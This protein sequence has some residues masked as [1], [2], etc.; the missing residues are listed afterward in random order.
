MTGIGRFSVGKGNILL[1][2]DDGARTIAG[3]VGAT[4]E[5]E[6]LHERDMV[7]HRRLMA[8]IGELAQAVG[9]SSEEMRA[10]LMV[11]ANLCDVVT[12]LGGKHVLVVHSMSRHAMK[13][14]ELH[15]LWES[16]KGHVIERVLPLVKNE[17]VRDRLRTAVE[18]F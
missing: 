6:V 10:Q 13:D 3:T 15:R 17:T 8:T 16:A 18:S 14:E 4:V 11:W 9:W 5:L 1:P 2:L 7:F 12:T